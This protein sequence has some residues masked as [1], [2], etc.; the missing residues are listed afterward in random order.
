VAAGSR[1][2]DCVRRGGQPEA[3]RAVDLD[4]R[5]PSARRAD[6]AAVPH[7]RHAD[8]RRAPAAHPRD[9]GP[10]RDPARDDD[11]RRGVHVDRRRAPAAL[12]VRA[13]RAAGRRHRRRL[14]EPMEPGTAAGVQV[15]LVARPTSFVVLIRAFVAQFLA[16][17]SIASEAQLRQAAAGL[18]AFLLAPGVLLLVELFPDYQYAVVR[19]QAGL[20]PFSTVEDLLAWMA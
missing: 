12:R 2:R 5:F 14:A 6:L 15:S 1:R 7:R 17:E 13:G 10:R 3:R 11:G 8:G 4:A 9:G 18:L 20:Q 16:P 19:A